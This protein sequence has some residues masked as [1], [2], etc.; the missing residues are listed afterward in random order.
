MRYDRKK[1]KNVSN[2]D[3]Q[4]ILL[5]VR[6]ARRAATLETAG[7]VDICRPNNKIEMMEKDVTEFIRRRVHKHHQSWI[8][9]PLDEVIELL[10]AKLELRRSTK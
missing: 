8:I 7:F 3:L 6:E 5:H 10:E 2:K 9:L 4:T 1:A